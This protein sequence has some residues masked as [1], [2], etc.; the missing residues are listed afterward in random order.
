[1]RIFLDIGA[2]L[3][4][5]V[6]AVTDPGYDF[7]R[8]EC[9]EPVP[10]CCDAIERI[11]D[12]QVRVHRFGLWDRSC[13][14]EIYDPGHL[15]ASV[16][17]DARRGSRSAVASFRR[18]SDWFRENLSDA[19]EIYLKLNCEGS[20]C[21]ILDDLIASGEIRKVRATLVHFDVRKVASQAHREGQTRQRL[22]DANL[23][24]VST[25]DDVFAGSVTYFAG[26]QRW[27][28]AAGARTQSRGVA[29]FAAILRFRLIPRVVR[30]SR[31][32]LLVRALVPRRLYRWLVTRF[33][34]YEV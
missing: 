34:G 26:V 29:D 5:T 27:L 3:G 25:A 1:M 19:D 6:K 17:A 23:A 11:G 32:S 8:I 9:F 33:K 18:A 16:F 7:D 14:H 30:A 31:L 4:E 28:D 22:R 21:D 10:A 20:E 2:H 12:P 13:D 24:N 15:G